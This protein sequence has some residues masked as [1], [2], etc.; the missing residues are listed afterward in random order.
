MKD[1]NVLGIFFGFGL[2]LMV[3]AVVFQTIITA[4]DSPPTSWREF[5]IGASLSFSGISLVIGAVMILGH[6]STK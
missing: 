6:L 1:M 2:F 4:S 5:W 3:L